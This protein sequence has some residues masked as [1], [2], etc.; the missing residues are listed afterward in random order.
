MPAELCT[1]MAAIPMTKRK[2]ELTSRVDWTDS[3]GLTGPQLA[4]AES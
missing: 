3:R 1:V 2:T 4:Q